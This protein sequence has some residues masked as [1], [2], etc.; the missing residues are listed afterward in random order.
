MQRPA[1]AQAPGY[2]TG[3]AISSFDPASGQFLQSFPQNEDI[4][5]TVVSQDGTKLYSPQDNGTVGY[6]R[7]LSAADGT[8]ASVIP[9]LSKGPKQ[10]RLSPS[11]NILYELSLHSASKK[12]WVAVVDLQAGKVARYIHV[13]P[14]Y[15]FDLAVSPDGSK[16][17]LATHNQAGC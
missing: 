13:S 7:V 6:L 11:G 4:G 12:A 2:I 15:P 14:G 3:V 5:A 10:A 1:L 9:G 16:L 17:Y 8:A